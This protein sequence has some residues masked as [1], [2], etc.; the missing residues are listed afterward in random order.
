MKQTWRWFGP[1]DSVSI[2]DMRQAGVQGVVSSLHHIP[3]GDLWSVNEIEERQQCIATAT[4]GGH[5]GLTWE[6]VESL[7]VSE[8]I[9]RQSGPW[10]EHIAHYQQS[11]RHLAHCGVQVV[12]YNFMPVLDWTRTNL[13]YELPDGARCMRYDVVDFA[14]FDIHVLQRALAASDYPE[15]IVSHAADRFSRMDSAAADALAQNVVCGLPGAAQGYSLDQL[16]EQ[17]ALYDGISADR[18]RRNQQEF[19]E[20]VIPVAEAAG[21][22]LCC[23]PDDPPFSLLGLPRVMSTEED[24]R[25]LINA[26]DSPANGITLCTGSLGVRAD[27]DL[28][29]MVGRLGNRIHFVHLRNIQR[30]SAGYRL[31][32][33]E[34][35]HLE[36]ATDMVAVIAALLAEE[37]RRKDAG[38]AD[39]AIPFRPD[40]GLEILT[41][42]EQET[43]PGYPAIGRLRGL[44]EL[45]GII[46]ALTHSRT[47]HA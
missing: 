29:G 45:R 26:V 5:S 1:E 30:E 38:R 19:L 47:V 15:E 46:T 31:S 16:R 39:S 20:L 42:L 9:K 23:H 34:S 2:N 6:V 43:Q 4:N 10:R 24:Y 22:R 33:H 37:Q 8:H 41:D 14:A 13:S 21:V 17:L 3:T 36:G 25:L 44:A 35:A 7:P 32:F 12:C 27:N 40:H 28:P 18:L 11:L